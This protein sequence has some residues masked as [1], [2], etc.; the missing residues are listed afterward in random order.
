[1]KQIEILDAWRGTK[2]KARSKDRAFRS[3]RIQFFVKC[4]FKNFQAVFA[5]RLWANVLDDMTGAVVLYWQLEFI[6]LYTA[7]VLE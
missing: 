2:K 3:E 5:G 4:T 6:D 1:M 7:K